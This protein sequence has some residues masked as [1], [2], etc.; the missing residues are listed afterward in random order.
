MKLIE[1]NIQQIEELCRK[2]KV[3]SLYVFGSI[4]TNKFS[5]S[6]DIDLLV[7][8]DKSEIKLT[9]Y[10]DNFFGFMYDMESLLSRKVDLVCDDAVRNPYFR[11]ELEETKQLIYSL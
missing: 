1:L 6:S 8:F 3:R 4:L 2:Y 5:E 11:Q 9:E 7:D 10:A